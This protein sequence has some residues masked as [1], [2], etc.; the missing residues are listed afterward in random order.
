[1][2]PR[3]KLVYSTCKNS[4]PLFL[5]LLV[6]CCF[7]QGPGW[8]RTKKK[9]RSE[10]LVTHSLYCQSLFFLFLLCRYNFQFCEDTALICLEPVY[11][12]SLS[13]L[14]KML[15]LFFVLLTGQFRN[16]V[17]KLSCLVSKLFLSAQKL[18]FVAWKPEGF[19]CLANHSLNQWFVG[20]GFAIT[21]NG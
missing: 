3:Y 8:V 21:P 7:Y 17:G 20:M 6:S 15:L 2:K 13:R 19:V 10:N 5:V 18:T 9:E 4:F 1:M 11:F 12:C 14:H 16:L